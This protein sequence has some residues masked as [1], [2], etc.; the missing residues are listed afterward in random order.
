MFVKSVFFACKDNEIKRK[1]YIKTTKK[2][3][4]RPKNTAQLSQILR[5]QSGKTER[6]GTEAKLK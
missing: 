1:E 4:N 2:M 6:S 5:W 3:T